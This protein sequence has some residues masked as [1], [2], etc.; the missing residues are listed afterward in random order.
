MLALKRLEAADD[1]PEFSCG[2]DDIDEFFHVDSIGGCNE[3]VC[4][5]YALMN[6]EKTVGFYSVSNDSIRKQDLP[7]SRFK[8]VMKIVPR[9]KRYSSMPAA[10]IG[11]LGVC[12]DSQKDGYGTMI[13]D[14]LKYSFTNQNKTG[15][16][17][18]VVDAY[19]QENVTS[20]YQK[21]GFDFLTSTD[22]DEE[23]RIMF[24]D[25]VSFIR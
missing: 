9:P 13:L 20:F 7:R 14:Y 15:C 4:V 21:N 18:L 3:L 8:K 19:N 12:K 10:K 11:R 2:D 6:D 16:R 22:A 24:F 25:L 23:T 1:R 17:F 5:T